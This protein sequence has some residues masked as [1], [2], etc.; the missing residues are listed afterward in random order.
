M[1]GIDSNSIQ[2]ERAKNWC[3]NI[4]AANGVDIEI[5]KKICNKIAKQL[6]WIFIFSMIFEMAALFLF[7]PDTTFEVFN[8]ISNLINNVD[9]SRPS[10]NYKGLA[11]LGIILWMPF[12]IVPI[13]ITFFWRKK[14]LKEEFQK[15]KSSMDYMPNYLLDSIFWDFNQELELNREVFNNQ[16]WNYQ[17]YIK[18]SSKEWKPQKIVLNSTA[19]Y[20]VYEAFIYDSKKLFANEMIVEVIE[21]YGQKGI[22]VE[23]CAFIK[24]DNGECFTMSEILMKLHQQVHG[25]DL[26]DSIYFEGLEKADS[27][28]DFPVYYLRCGS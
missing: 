24:S 19:F 13:A 20:C 6:I 1:F 11:L 21:D 8:N 5:K 25:K 14:R 9:R 12:V 10:G 23:I 15:L 27:M 22:L 4:E 7:I 18:R 16:V 28:K 26:G 3:K 17:V 2:I